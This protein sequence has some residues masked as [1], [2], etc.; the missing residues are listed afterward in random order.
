MVSKLTLLVLGFSLILVDCRPT[1]AP[2][3]EEKEEPLSKKEKN[4]K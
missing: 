2:D 3:D 4:R 1:T